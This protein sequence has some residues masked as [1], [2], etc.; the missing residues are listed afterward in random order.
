MG[1]PVTCH[2]RVASPP[3]V[4]AR[5]RRD[6]QEAVPSAFRASPAL[7]TLLA[8]RFVVG[9]ILTLTLTLTL[10]RFVVGYINQQFRLTF[11]WLSAG[12]GISAVVSLRLG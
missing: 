5:L 10:T 7:S 4:L 12:G 11:L 6:R 1:M 2:G 8:R 9:Y 3:A